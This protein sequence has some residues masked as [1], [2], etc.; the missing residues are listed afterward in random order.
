MLR[1]PTALAPLLAL[2]VTTAC[3]RDTNG[4]NAPNGSGQIPAR[5]GNNDPRGVDD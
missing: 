2:L 3:L 1:L 4:N 5:V